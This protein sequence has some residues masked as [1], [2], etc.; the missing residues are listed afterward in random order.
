MKKLRNIE[1]RQRALKLLA[2]DTIYNT[3]QIKHNFRRQMKLVNPHGPNRFQQFVPGYS[4]AEIA[5]LIIQAYR[6]LTIGTGPTTMLE[7]DD[8]VG[9]M[10]EGD[11]TP[12]SE[13]AADEDWNVNQFYDQYRHSIWP[14][15]SEEEKQSA[16][17]KFR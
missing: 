8:L 2:V 3:E 7:N 15:A 13:T 9:T 4:N 12:M 10:L 17:H 16:K 6:F 14:E 5:R 1:L 11:I